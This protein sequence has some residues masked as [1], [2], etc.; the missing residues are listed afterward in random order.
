M[1]PDPTVLAS[2]RKAV[3]AMP[4]DVPLR[5]HLA[6]LLLQAGQR[7]EAIRHVG[8]V[9]QRD[10]GNTEALALLQRPA[11]PRPPPRPPPPPQVPPATSAT[12]A[13]PDNATG[14]PVPPNSPVP[15]AG[16]P[17]AGPPAPE[18]GPAGAPPPRRPRAAYWVP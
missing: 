8:A 11:A 18:A 14:G 9:L 17:P 7:D 10:P 2:L 6:T 5:V 13:G 16:P 12:S 15:P 4:D 1:E 3:E